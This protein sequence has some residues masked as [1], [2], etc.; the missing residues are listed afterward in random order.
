MAAVGACERLLDLTVEHV[1]Q[2]EQFGR[3]IG[4]F[5]AVKHALADVYIDVQHSRSLVFAA[6]CA[7]ADERRRLLPLAKLAAD[8]TYRR[9]AETALQLHGG[10]G[11]TWE[12]PVH[13]FLKNALRLS[14]YP[15]PPT[16]QR[17]LV[18][19]QL[20]LEPA[21]DAAPEEVTR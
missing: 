1:R 6:L 7:E 10:I 12:C 8:A 18:G 13:L 2:R 3:P 15:V 14:T 16:S 11:F 5:Q 21:H 4:S 20:G 9:T 17:T 19:G